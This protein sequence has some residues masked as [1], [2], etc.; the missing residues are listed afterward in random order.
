MRAAAWRSRRSGSTHAAVW[1][2]QCGNQPDQWSIQETGDGEP[3]VIALGRGEFGFLSTQD[4]RA[5][6]LPEPRPQ[7]ILQRLG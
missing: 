4:G 7:W 3:A 1:V 5:A 6:L 2:D